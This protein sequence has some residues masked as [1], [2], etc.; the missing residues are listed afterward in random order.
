MVSLTK[1]GDFYFTCLTNDF[2]LVICLQLS[3]ITCFG[4]TS[5][6]IQSAKNSDFVL[7][8]FSLFDLYIALYFFQ[9]K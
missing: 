8:A 1:L 3:I 7:S 2:E 6:A 4:L 5:S 9:C